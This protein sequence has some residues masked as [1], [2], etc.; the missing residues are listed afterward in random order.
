[1][2]FVTVTTV[3]AK[4]L[5]SLLQVKPHL[6]LVSIRVP[7]IPPNSGEIITFKKNGTIV[8]KSTKFFHE[9]S[10]LD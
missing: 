3:F 7:P 10:K 6:K 9:Y 2:Y 5:N 8:V 4:K 1:M